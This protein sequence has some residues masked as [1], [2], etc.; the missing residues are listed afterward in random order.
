MM[1]DDSQPI[2]HTAETLP[3]RGGCGVMAAQ[4]GFEARSKISGRQPDI[5]FLRRI[6]DV[7]GALGLRSLQQT[8][9]NQTQS[10]ESFGAGAGLADWPGSAESMQRVEN[11]LVDALLRQ[12]RP[13]AAGLAE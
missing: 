11:S 4:G 7:R 5:I 3:A 9:V 2:R 6:A 13:A 1:I 10:P 8:A 12:R